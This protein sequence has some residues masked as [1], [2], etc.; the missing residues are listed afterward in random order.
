MKILMLILFILTA[1]FAQAKTQ[2]KPLVE[3]TATSTASIGLSA[4]HNRNY[5]LIQNLGPDDVYLKFISAP[6]GT[7]GIKIPLG[8]NYEAYEAPINAFYVIT[9][10]ST[11]DLK[12]YEGEN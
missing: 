12:I 4:N 7:D 3:I 6:T 9:P 8:G 2:V 5:L 11:A 10:S 1:S